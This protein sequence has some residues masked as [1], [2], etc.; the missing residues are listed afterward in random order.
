[1]T[2]RSNARIPKTPFTNGQSDALEKFLPLLGLESARALRPVHRIALC[3]RFHSLPHINRK[4][5]I[6][7]ANQLDLIQL[8][9]QA[10]NRLEVKETIA[11]NPALIRRQEEI[12]FAAQLLK[13]GSAI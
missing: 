8:A 6:I 13:M 9:L 1:M 5:V 7:I 12:V 2:S 10:I 4:N 3:S 11:K